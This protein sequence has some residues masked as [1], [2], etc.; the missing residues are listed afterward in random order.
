MNRTDRV[1]P[2]PDRSCA[3]HTRAVR[4]FGTPAEAG[5]RVPGSPAA[6]AGGGAGEGGR[7]L[8]GFVAS[9]EVAEWLKAAVC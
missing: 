9:G 5:Y 8:L 2:I 1:L 3:C 6:R 4:G 7:E